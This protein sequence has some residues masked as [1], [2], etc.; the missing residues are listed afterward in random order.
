M[1]IA[2]GTRFA[3]AARPARAHEYGQRSLA[4]SAVFAVNR[5]G[6]ATCG[7]TGCAGGSEAPGVRF[8]LERRGSN[9]VRLASRQA[10]H[11][12]RARMRLPRPPISTWLPSWR[13]RENRNEVC[14]LNVLSMNR[15]PSFCARCQG[16]LPRNLGNSSNLRNLGGLLRPDE[17]YR[18]W[19]PL[20]DTRCPECR[21]RAASSLYLV[22]LPRDGT[23]SRDPAETLSF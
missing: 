5:A 1:P 19:C 23:P 17:N 3:P 21:H 11:T 13:V 20:T 9:L 7:G 18:S 2:I 22:D 10:S 16:P 4:E 14:R 8:L 6:I 15:L 12:S